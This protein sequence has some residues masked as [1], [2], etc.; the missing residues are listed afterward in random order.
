MNLYGAKKQAVLAIPVE[1][2]FFQ[3][4]EIRVC[5]IHIDIDAMLSSLTLQTS[6][7][8]TYYNLYHAA[9]KA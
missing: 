7:E 2:I 5:F 9:G 8:E 6:G 4:A 3:G 1:G